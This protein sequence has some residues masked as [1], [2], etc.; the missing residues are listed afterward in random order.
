LLFI[1]VQTNSPEAI[2]KLAQAR[3][4]KEEN[5]YNELQ[6]VSRRGGPGS[7]PGQVMWDL[8]WKEWHWVRFSPS[9]SVSP[10]NP[11]STDCFIIIIAHPGLVQ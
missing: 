8:W 3:T 11:H 2:T 6:A 7:I 5:T 10:A 9:T 1:Y 4:T